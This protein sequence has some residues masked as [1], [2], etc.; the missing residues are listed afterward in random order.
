M[1]LR[2]AEER[3]HVNHGWLNTWHT[4][5]FASYFDR[6]H[7][8]HGVLRV[9]NDDIVAAGT[10]FPTHPHD[11]MEIITYVLSG[12]LSHRDSMGHESIIY[13]GDIQRMSAGSGLTHSE[14]NASAEEPVHLLQIWLYPKSKDIEPNYSQTTLTREDKLNKLVKVVS[15]TPGDAPLLMHQDAVMYASIVAD[16]NTVAMP[17]SN[18]RAYWLHLVEGDVSVNGVHMKTG[19]SA[20]LDGEKEL[21][22]TGNGEFLFFDMPLSRK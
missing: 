20:A 1:I 19:D 14:F 2:K 13:A 15:G 9:I 22:V 17:L 5:S 18:G 8:G 16:G 11:N 3:G 7:M 21:I 10:G 6:N 12:A 4:F